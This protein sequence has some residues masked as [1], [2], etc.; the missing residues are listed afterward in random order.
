MLPRRTSLSRTSGLTTATP[1]ARTTGLARTGGLSSTGPVKA[2]KPAPTRQERD[3]K[4]STKTRSPLWCEIRIDGVCHGRGLD[5][6]H[7]IAQSQGGPWLASNGIR[8]C[9][10]CHQWC[11]QNPTVAKAHGWFVQPTYRRSDTQRVLIPAAEFPALLWIISQ[12]TPQWVHLHDDSRVTIAD[13]TVI[14]D[15]LAYPAAGLGMTG[16]IAGWTAQDQAAF[17]DAVAEQRGER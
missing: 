16:G 9:R 3:A 11:H 10:A 12:P 6:S 5:F 4:Q 17:A 1:L 8:V 14:A 15:W 2:R 7:R 13:L